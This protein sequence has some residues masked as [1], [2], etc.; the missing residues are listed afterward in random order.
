MLKLI[1]LATALFAIAAPSVAQERRPE[2]PARGVMRFDTN[3]DG[4]VDRSEWKTAQDARFT[5]FD[6]DKDGKL[7]A[8]ELSRRPV[9]ATGVLPADAQ[10]T[11]QSAFFRRMDTDRDGFVSKVEYLAEAERRFIRCDV[12]KEGRI[13]S[14]TC[15]QGMGRQPASTDRR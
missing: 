1:S 7:T 6:A 15:R 13:N 5:Q 8:D 3:K 12:K 11:R 14:D 2:I 4:V 10:N 9:G